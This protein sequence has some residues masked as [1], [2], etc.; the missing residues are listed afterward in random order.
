MKAN[1]KQ[2]KKRRIYSEEFKREIV[3]DFESGRFSVSQLE[4]LYGVSNPTIYQWIYKFSTFNEKG[5][6]VIEKKD[7]S[8]DK[9][10]KLED[11]VK[12]LEGI[13]GRKQIAIDYLEKT[14]EIASDELNVDIKKNSNTLQSAG[15][16]KI[17]Q[18]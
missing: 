16:E 5:F 13:I 6:R 14:I 12:E 1:L 2:L 7:S 11:R 8:S 9:L 18:K 15:F 10:K 17:N 3:K 4:K